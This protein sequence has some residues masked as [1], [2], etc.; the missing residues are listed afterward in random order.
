[1][2]GFRLPGRPRAGLQIVLADD[3]H[4]TFDTGVLPA[5]RIVAHHNATLN[6][7][8]V[9]LAKTADISF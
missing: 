5:E 8:F 1:M 4:T 3:A 2:R 9:E 6:G 7:A